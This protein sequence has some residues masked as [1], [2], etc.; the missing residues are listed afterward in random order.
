MGS[1]ATG[2]AAVNRFV[3]VALLVLLAGCES[4]ECGR[5]R[6]FIE[7]KDRYDALI[8]WADKTIF[9]RSIREED[10]RDLGLVGPGRK[11][12][13]GKGAINYQPPSLPAVEIRLIGK[14]LYN[15]DAVFL[16]EAS[17]KGLIVARGDVADAISYSSILPDEVLLKKARVALVCRPFR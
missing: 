14:D 7:E 5:Y 11:R 15:P 17:F 1:I 16:G 3:I 8:D 12:L 6:E 4:I 9:S 13:R 2:A 10:V